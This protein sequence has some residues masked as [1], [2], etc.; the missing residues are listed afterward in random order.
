MEL[1][2]LRELPQNTVFKEGDI[3]VL[4]G[5]LFG[6]GYVNGLLKQARECKMRIIGLTVGRRNADKTL[7]ALSEEELKE[8][9][10]NIG[11]EIINIPLEAGF[12]MESVDGV[13][14][15][16]MANAIDKNQW[17]E[18]K[19][20]NEKILACKQAAEKKFCE[21][22]EQFMEVL[23]QMIPADKN[24]FF[25][26]TM[27]GG[28]IRSKLFFIIANR[29]FKGR[30]DRFESSEKY[31]NRDLGQL[32]AKSFETVTADTFDF[33]LRF[34]KKIRERNESNGASVFYSA[35]GYHGCEVLIQNQ[36]R[37]QTYV[38]YQQGHAKKKLENYAI[39]ARNQNIQASVFNCPEIRT[40]SS[41]IFL[42]V[43]L[44]LFFLLIALKKYY[45]SRWSDEQWTKCQSKLREGI[46]LESILKELED[47][48]LSVEIQEKFSFEDWPTENSPAFSEKI[49]GI[50]EK[51]TG[52]H[53]D[54]K[55]LISDYLS[56]FV[57]EATGSLI[58]QYA[59]APKKPVIWL[60]HDII[61][62][63]LSQLYA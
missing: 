4:F 12:D 55:D 44:S 30:G 37:W 60:G 7:R 53:T 27:A 35:Y 62:K 45:S 2:G 5:E 36:M 43:E 57:V 21:K 24:I 13:S 3:F 52:L 15:V 6:R 22:L 9:E 47:C 33:L 20:D 63:S 59:S 42:G 18:A 14:P 11:G 16:D 38:P 61:A 23:E 50:S 34:S 51:I 26:H 46:K 49:I 32:C 10:Q 19:L 29:V 54:R 39:A 56:N 31:W 25:A 41:S 28:I 17:R 40:N 58:F 1:V 48:L 8:A